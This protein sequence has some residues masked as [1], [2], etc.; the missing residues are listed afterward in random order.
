MSF[1]MNEADYCVSMCSD[2]TDYTLEGLP[3]IRIV[4]NALY[5]P[6]NPD[7]D[8]DYFGIFDQYG[9]LVN[10]CS[11]FWHRDNILSVHPR[12]AK[13]SH[14]WDYHT[15]DS[16]VYCGHIS[17]HYGHVLLDFIARLWFLNQNVSVPK[18]ILVHSSFTKEEILARSW[19]R[20]ILDLVGID[21]QNIH[22]FDIPI[23]VRRLY[24][25]NP[26]CEADSYVY[27]G[28]LSF[29]HELGDKARLD[30]PPKNRPVYLSR[31]KLDRGTSCF[32]RESDIVSFF[33]KKGI[34]EIF[35]EQLSI[36]EQIVN[37]SSA[38]PVLGVS[39]SSFHTSIFSRNPKA[40]GIHFRKNLT[41][42]FFSLDRA[43]GA[44]IDYLYARSAHPIFPTHEGFAHT[45]KIENINGFCEDVYSVWESKFSNN[46]I[47]HEE[48]N[49]HEDFFYLKDYQNKWLKV[50]KHDGQIVAGND[51]GEDRISC[52]LKCVSK[53]TEYF[54]IADHSTGFPIQTPDYRR[55]KRRIPVIRDGVY[56]Q[57]EKG[58]YLRSPS[59]DNYC[60]VDFEAVKPDMWEMFSF[61]RPENAGV[62]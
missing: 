52:M 36:K 41:E 38:Y 3:D 50:M 15:I 4:P 46:K 20:E 28:F 53:G 2:E 59:L 34:E 45:I 24:A 23:K 21:P 49:V 1:I 32:E 25:P 16:A 30:T 5:L 9:R 26:G 62:S 6:K 48:K 39:G 11:M 37:F 19:F 14:L 22:I 8:Q 29:C 60:P 43:N 27:K 33:A 57:L 58:R 55:G 44:D 42:T 56:L 13:I 47:V 61:I 54:L 51:F 17:L 40:V 18:K 7:R 35:P 10:E 12:E 31:R